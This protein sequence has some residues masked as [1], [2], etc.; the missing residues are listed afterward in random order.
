VLLLGT[1]ALERLADGSPISALLVGFA[2]AAVS[3]AAYTWLTRRIEHRSEVTELATPGAARKVGLGVLLGGG[4]FTAVMLLIGAFGGWERV[5]AGSVGGLLI[6]VGVM[7]LVAV[8][9]E[10]LF[11]GVLVRILS[12]RF[13]GWVALIV[14]SLIFGGLHLVNPDATVWGALAIAATGGLLLGG[15][16]LATGSL[17]LPIG[18]HFAW[19]LTESG[20]FG[21]AT[22]GNGESTA[23]L[24]HTALS[25]PT[26]LTGGQFG[27]EASLVVLIVGVIPAA[28]LIR[29]ASR[30]GRMRSRRDLTAPASQ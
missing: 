22:S 18:I 17:W 19:N 6:T 12:E 30:T 27:P 13:G 9:E 23:S 20:I 15:A 1:E 4:T 26:V 8:N 24:W 10:L 16:Y 11:R 2:A 3:L 5:T 21:T 28:L 7:A 14:S 25:G 29:H